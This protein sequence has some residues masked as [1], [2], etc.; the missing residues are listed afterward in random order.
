MLGTAVKARPNTIAMF[1][2][3][4]LHM[5]A[6]VLADQEELTYNSSVRTLDTL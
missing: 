6:P 2:N 5:N 3:E 1:L 4:L